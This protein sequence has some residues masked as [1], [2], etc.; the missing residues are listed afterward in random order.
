MTSDDT[1][2]STTTQAVNRRVVSSS[3][4]CGANLINKLR[5]PDWCP[6]LH[7]DVDCDVTLY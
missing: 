5:A 6:F 2:C 3:L 4:T 1:A 7:C